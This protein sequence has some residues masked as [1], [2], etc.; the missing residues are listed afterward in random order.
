MGTSFGGALAALATSTAPLTVGFAQSTTPYVAGTVY[1]AQV[2]DGVTL[3][4][5][6]NAEGVT[7]TGV[8]TPATV[9]DSVSKVWTPQGTGWDWSA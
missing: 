4:A 5:D 1:K 8:R 9:T 3:V 6:F 2:Y 7:R